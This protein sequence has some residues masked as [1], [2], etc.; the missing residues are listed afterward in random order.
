MYVCVYVRKQNLSPYFAVIVVV[1]IETESLIA[2]GSD[3]LND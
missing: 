1:D 2:D 3:D